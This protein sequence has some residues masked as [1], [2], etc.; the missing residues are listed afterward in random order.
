MALGDIPSLPDSFSVEELE[1]YL[2]RSVHSTTL[3][4]QLQSIP[5]EEAGRSKTVGQKPSNVKK[6]R[7]KNNV[8]YNETRVVL[9]GDEQADYI[10]ASYIEGSNGPRDFIAAQGPKEANDRTIEDFWRMVW[11]EQCNVIVMLGNLIE[12]GLGKVGQYW[13][14]NTGVKEQYGQVQVEHKIEKKYVDYTR[15]LLVVSVGSRSRDVVQYQYTGWPDHEVPSSPF[16]VATM[17]RDIARWK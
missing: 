15:R 8:P 14:P 4:I 2:V 16:G 11:Q 9:Q 10:N 12:G 3:D 7:Y 17:I 13:P 5:R 1:N 6:N